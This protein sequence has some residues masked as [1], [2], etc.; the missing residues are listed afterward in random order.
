MRVTIDLMK[1]STQIIDLSNVINPRVGDDDLLLP[2]HIVYGDNQTDMRGKDVEFLSNDPNKKNIYI[3]GTCNTNTPGDNLYM[4]DLT[5]RFPAGTFKVDGTYDP[6]KTMFR[7]V[8]KETQKV[9]S[10]VNVKITVMKNNI[11]FDFDPDKSSY[12]SRA[13]TMLQDFHDKG[14]AMLNEI[15]DL[16]SQ[17]NSNVSG[18]TATTA[19]EAKKQAGQ[20]A[21]DISDLKEEVAG[22]RG[23]FANMAGRENAQD[24][25]INQKESIVNANANY[26]ALKQKDSEQ[27]VRI[28][29]KANQ[30]FIVNYL[31]R[32]HSEPEG[33][34]DLN[35]L[36]A[37]YPNG[38]EGI[39]ITT[40]DGHFY[41][42]FNNAW[43][44]R[45]VFQGKG[46]ANRS[47]NNLNIKERTLS[48][49]TTQLSPWII[50]FD[51]HSFTVSE[52]S[53][54]YDESAHEIPKGVYYLSDFHL[55]F[56]G[57][58]AVKEKFDG[59]TRYE[60][61]PENSYYIGVVDFQTRQVFLQF[62]YVDADAIPNDQLSRTSKIRRENLP[63]PA[64]GL[65]SLAPWSVDVYE[66]PT[67]IV[68]GYAAY[69]TKESFFG[70][71]SGT[72]TFDKNEGGAYYIYLDLNYTNSTAEI[73]SSPTPYGIPINDPWIGFIETNSHVYRIFDNSDNLSYALS[74][75][76]PGKFTVNFE[77]NTLH[78][79]V[80]WHSINSLRAGDP[81]DSNIDIKFDGSQAALFVGLDL[82]ESVTNK[83]LVLDPDLSKIQNNYQYLGWIS[84]STQEYDFGEYGSTHDLATQPWLNKNVAC[85][86]DSIT[87]GDSGEG[88]LIDSYVPK[89]KKYI[90]TN[91]QNFG[92]SGA[93]ITKKTDDDISFVN[94]VGAIKGQDVVTIF[95]GINDFQWNA[96]L[97]TMADGIDKPTTFFG[98]L[99]YVITTLAANN[100]KAK[101]ML[102]TPMKTTKF[103][104]HTYDNNGNLMQ[105]ANGNTQLDFV[106]AIKQVGEYYSIPVLDMYSNSN[107]SPY[108]PSQVGHDNFTADGL[109]PTAHGYERIAQTIGHAIN[110]L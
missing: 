25:A 77:N 35:T 21:G 71:K 88:S 74:L 110:N 65:I 81:V 89:L 22:A 99:K 80:L 64:T 105:N 53:T 93:L 97:G 18:D 46:I 8:D 109:H 47:I 20:N 67:I 102:I 28:N 68:N 14:Q 7:I 45:G 58:D 42:W 41:L 50:D 84:I 91:A 95:G 33:F 86:G 59:Y 87:E 78:V 61:I 16:K 63:A 54:F 72:Y 73:K 1:K 56:I 15:K 29:N 75:I 90:G 92:K 32:M 106:N 40:D 3:A 27:D 5:F 94:R 82:N 51:K 2:L 4:G 30:D 11:E 19:K 66:G 23:R 76:T 36:K 57:Y 104:Y 49:R 43:N 100:P 39:M 96:P 60:D 24:A 10:S 31:T 13:E 98:A 44:D 108:L 85:L 52:F 37:T 101:L 17:A 55:V 38:K 103:Q 69:A 34:T 48:L 70:I 79:P 83:M 9:I 6:D 62:D 26:M 12:D 107:Y